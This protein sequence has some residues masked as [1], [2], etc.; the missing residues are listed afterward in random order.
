[1]SIIKNFPFLLHGGDYNPD[2]WIK[3]PGIIDD[4][5]RMMDEASCNTFSISIFSWGQIERTEGVFDFSWLDDI[6]AR[7]AAAGKKVFL[8]TPSGGRPAWLGCNYPETNRVDAKGLRATWNFRHNHCWSSPVMREKVSVINRKL[9]QRYAAHPA[10]GG[11][12]ISNEY[13]GE[14][15]CEL[16]RGNFHEFL[17]QRYG[18]L[19]KLNDAYWSAFWSHTLT[20]WNQVNPEDP[21]LD[22]V[23]LDWKRF[24]S[25]QIADFLKF[26]IEAVR[27]FSD[28]PATTNM[29]G[30]IPDL[31][32]WR[33]AE[34]CDFIADDC[35][36]RWINGAAEE[37]AAHFSLVHDLHYTM[38]KKPFVMMESCPGVPNYGKYGKMR[39][40]NEFEREML[41]AIGHG[42]DGTLYFQWRKGLG[43]CEK[44][45]GAVVSHDGTNQTRTFKAVAEYGRKLKSLAEVADSTTEPEA[46]LIF[47]WESN[48]ALEYTNGFGGETEKRINETAIQH[49][50]A[51]W[52]S[53][54]PL[55]VIESTG[56]FTP[57]KVLVAPMLF[58]LKP[59]V[60]D[61]LKAFV[62]S[63]GTLVATYLSAYVDENNRCFFGGNPGGNPLRRLF[64]IW[65]EDIDCIEP[66]DHRTFRWRNGEI[67][68]HDYTEY[69]HLEGAEATAVYGGGDFFAGTPAVT[70]NAFGK[71]KA[72]YIGARTGTDFLTSFYGGILGDNQ[73]APVLPDLPKE[74]RASKRSKG[75]ADFYFICNLSG[76]EVQAGLPSPMSNLWDGGKVET[77]V[78]VPPNGAAVLKAESDRRGDR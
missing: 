65:N 69:L 26:E 4:D 45:H 71:G 50:Q 17:R 61:R 58:M 14:C 32:Y 59:G 55:A 23:R 25:R 64:G 47:D 76:E 11:W 35:Y 77:T 36:P 38:K 6:M 66:S 29:M 74:L 34:P 7:C 33:I 53:N 30:I 67:A 78:T 10:L 44:Y 51:L 75:N 3:K 31:D 73:I 63:G 27:E 46:A 28:A 70:V 21:T 48:W 16:C 19:E 49:Y 60:G 40:P 39:R 15:F 72:W 22:A 24:N 20:D 41:L 37:V 1:M 54:V 42:A 12:H 2:Q 68:A 13:S 43:N 8:A 62:E 9:A 56:D 18:T 5:F 52:R 57:Y